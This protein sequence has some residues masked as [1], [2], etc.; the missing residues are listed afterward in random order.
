MQVHRLVAFS[1]CRR[2]N[3]ARASAL[4]LHTA[5]CFLLDMLYVRAAMADNL[6]AKIESGDW[7]EVDGNLLIWPFFLCIGVSAR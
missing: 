6:C 1:A 4:N 5:A 7:V 3:K 2:F